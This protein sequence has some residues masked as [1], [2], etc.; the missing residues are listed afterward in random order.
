MIDK[1]K[2]GFISKAELKLAKKK[3]GM[4]EIDKCIKDLDIDGDGKLNMDEFKQ[5]RQKKK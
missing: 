4:K 5:P 1:N 2:D 3:L